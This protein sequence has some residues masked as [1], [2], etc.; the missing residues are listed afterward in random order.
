MRAL[1]CH[2]GIAQ[3]VRN[4]SE[5]PFQ[6]KTSQQNCGEGLGCQET[7]IITQ[8][9]P[10]LYLLLIKGCT[11]AANQEA[12]VTEHRAGPGL[13]ITSYTRVC[14][15]AGRICATTS[16]PASLSGPRSHPQSQVLCSVQSACLQKAVCRSQR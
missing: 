16:P 13:S 15:Y 11:Q 10:L 12:R 9:E 8:N 2:W 5:Q 6:W 14:R 1:N 7:V 3:T 4:V